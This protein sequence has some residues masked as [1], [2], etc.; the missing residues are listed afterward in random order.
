MA[1]RVK[2]VSKDFVVTIK[3]KSQKT[4]L[5]IRLWMKNSSKPQILP[6]LSR[7]ST[8]F[9]E[10]FDTE[11]LIF[12][13]GKKSHF[14]SF[15]LYSTV[16]FLLKFTWRSWSLLTWGTKLI[17]ASFFTCWQHSQSGWPMRERR[18]YV[19]W[20]LSLPNLFRPHLF[21]A[22]LLKHSLAV[23]KITIFILL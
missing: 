6:C 17:C 22:S 3:P 1:F 15:L 21:L 12:Q 9:D 11:F 4:S 18:V 2:K 19:R 23:H 10:F 20:L 14:S 8:N 16:H 7:T 5:K 13:N